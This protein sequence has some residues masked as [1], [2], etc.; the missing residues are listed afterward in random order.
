MLAHLTNGCSLGAAAHLQAYLPRFRSLLAY[1]GA[2]DY[3]LEAKR[4]IWRLGLAYLL[5]SCLVA[6]G[7]EP[8]GRQ[9]GFVD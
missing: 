1:L 5:F 7:P 6:Y 3:Y 8:R 4:L 2:E 9:L